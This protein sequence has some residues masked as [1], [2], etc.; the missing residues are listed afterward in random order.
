MLKSSTQ[1]R[2]RYAEVD[3]M[4]F[5]HHSNYA[6]YYEVA[7]SILIREIGYP[8]NEMEA[9]GVLMPVVKMN[10]K[11]LKPAR[12]EDLITIETIMHETLNDSFVTFFH[13]LYNEKNE[14]IHKGEITLT[15]FDP[16]T[17]KR[18]AMPPKLKLF[19]NNH[20]KK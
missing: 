20:L 3:Q 14:L 11:F 10:A 2:V 13:K 4:G 9:D 18:I 8:Y 7:R 19:M 12:Y 6:I 15:F 16:T 1:I 5:M 17:Q